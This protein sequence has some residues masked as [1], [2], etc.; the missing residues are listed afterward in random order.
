MV[1][2]NDSRN[3][4]M[5]IIGLGGRGRSLLR[6]L[7]HVEG[8]DI[9]ALSDKREKRLNMGLE[10]VIETGR[11]MPAGYI[12]HKE[13]LERDDIEGIIIATG[14]ISHIEL[15]VETMRSGKYAGVEVGGAS[16]MEECWSLI[17]AYEETG[18]HC[19]M[20]ENCCYGRNEMAMLNIVKQGVFGEVI[21]CQ[22]GYQHDLREH[23]GT[24]KERN[25]YRIHH[26]LHRNGDLYPTH[27]LG[28]VAKILN[29]NRGNRFI[30]LSAMSSKARGL[31]TWLAGHYGEDH[32]MAKAEITQG[33]IVTTMIEC[34]HGETVLIIHDTTLPR[35]YSRGL[36][37]QGTEGIWMEDN[38]S[39]Y[40]EGKSPEHTWED[41]EEYREEYDHPLWK[42]YIK[43]GIKEGH[44]GMDYL[45]LSAFVESIDRG[46]EPPIDTYDT[47]AWMAVTALSEQ[48]IAQGGGAVDFPDFTNGK[49]IRKGTGPISKYSLDKV[50]EQIF[51]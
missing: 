7:M 2:S 27:G 29:I 8:V 32:E 44:G 42:E 1:S 50:D 41:F 37:I 15:A 38:D 20:L 12:D 49:W 33:D 45:C 19:M 30:K 34:A 16:S 43:E 46:I 4:R 40:I 17:R 9:V 6:N 11:E 10:Q 26:Y 5:G 48:S 21:H 14:W 24:G 25:H 22:C 51:K 3:V 36:R 47:A 28:P 39:I 31:H 13:M 18:V 23:I 35:P